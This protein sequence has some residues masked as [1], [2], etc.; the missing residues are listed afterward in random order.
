MTTSSR[1]PATRPTSL[2]LDRIAFVSVLLVLSLPV[3]MLWIAEAFRGQVRPGMA[4]GGVAVV[5]A[6]IAG[7]CLAVTLFY[8]GDRVA[9]VRLVPSL[10]GFRLPRIR[11]GHA[12][13][14]AVFF[15][16]VL[17]VVGVWLMLNYLFP[18]IFDL[19][20]VTRPAGQ[21]DDRDSWYMSTPL[22]WTIVSI[23]S[24]V[25]AEEILFRGPG[26]LLWRLRDY[27]IHPIVRA[28]LT[29]GAIVGGLAVSTIA[30]GFVHHD[31]GAWNVLGAAI[32]GALI[33][34]LALATGSLWP[35]IAA[36]T[37]WNLV[38]FGVLTL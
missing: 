33:Y 11:P 23:I 28:G 16:L 15:S 14:Q 2:P 4:A 24:G 7:A 9:A 25:I 3:G 29:W 21:V 38:A 18:A 26:L 8:R 20:G 37:L 30:F 31:H 10:I 17:P 6:F 34:P 36:H 27:T 19:T 35:S 5:A 13:V 12:T 22:A 1:A 32:F